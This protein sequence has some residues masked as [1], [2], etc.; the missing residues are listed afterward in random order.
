MLCKIEMNLIK[1]IE[2]YRKSNKQINKKSNEL[3]EEYD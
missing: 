3:N 2:K 1:R